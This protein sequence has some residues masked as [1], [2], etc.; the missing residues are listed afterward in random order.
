[1]NTLKFLSQ[2]QNNAPI[3]ALL[4]ILSKVTGSSTTALLIKDEL[5]LTSGES[6]EFM[7]YI[8]KLG[9]G[10]PLAYLLGE[11]GFYDRL[12]YVNSNVLIPRPD[13]EQIIDLTLAQFPNKNEKLIILDMGTGSGIIPITLALKYSSANCFAIDL[14]DKA[15]AVARK[16]SIRHAVSDRV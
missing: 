1:M 9:S 11:W 12:F 16:N 5:N 3:N 15:L 4:L 8:S 2:F 14:S 13:T 6:S 10:M 7:D